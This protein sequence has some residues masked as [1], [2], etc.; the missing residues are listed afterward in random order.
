MQ[1]CEHASDSLLYLKILFFPVSGRIPELWDMLYL[2]STAGFVGRHI[3]LSH[4]D[5]RCY[6][7]LWILANCHDEEWCYKICCMKLYWLTQTS[8]KAIFMHWNTSPCTKK[9]KG[10][11]RRRKWNPNITGFVKTHFLLKYS[12]LGNRFYFQLKCYLLA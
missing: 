1:V 2:E 10:G 5:C 9:K 11:G 7:L 12:P 3:A 8:Y 6:V 4:C